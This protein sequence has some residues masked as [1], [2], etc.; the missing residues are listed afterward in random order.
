MTKRGTER[1]TKRGTERDTES[2]RER[3][4]ERVTERVTERG[5]GERL[6]I[7]TG[8]TPPPPGNKVEN[9]E[10]YYSFGYQANGV[11][12][13]P[14][15]GRELANLIAESNSKDLSISKLYQGLPKT[16]PFPS[17]RL[18]YLKLAYLYYGLIKLFLLHE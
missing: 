4:A 14:W 13:A 16:F 7:A 3:D 5:T 17:L 12:T 18:L 11:N 8:P 10:I 1:V 15:A 6:Y 9:D 2:D